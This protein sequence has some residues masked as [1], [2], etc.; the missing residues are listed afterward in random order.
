MK[1]EKDNARLK[2]AAAQ[3]KRQYGETGQGFG[4]QPV[5]QE[6]TSSQVVLAKR[7]MSKT[8]LTN[9]MYRELISW[10]GLFTS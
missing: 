7:D 3:N 10:L 5:Q 4:S 1:F 9:T 6:I 2:K 8:K